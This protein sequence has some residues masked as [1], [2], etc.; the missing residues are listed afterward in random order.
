M[1]QLA[2]CESSVLAASLLSELERTRFYGTLEMKFEAG[3]VVLIRKT[4]TL[5]PS[6]QRRD[7]RGG[8][9]DNRP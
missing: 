5:K 7:N 9:D 6:C 3:H 8:Q 2:D 4:E 1:P